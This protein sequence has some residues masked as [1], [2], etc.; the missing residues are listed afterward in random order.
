[1]NLECSQ[2]EYQ[3]LVHSYVQPVEVG[4]YKE[5]YAKCHA[6][7]RENKVDLIGSD[8]Q[9]AY[10]NSV[11]GIH[12]TWE[13]FVAILPSDQ[14]RYCLYSFPMKQHNTRDKLVFILWYL[15]F[16]T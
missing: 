2:Y 10:D 1:V 14:P 5:F 15:P 12:K 16:G 13:E 7:Q 6:I 3:P 8:W 9:N 4:S 11:C